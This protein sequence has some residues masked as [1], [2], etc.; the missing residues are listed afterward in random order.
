V[1]YPI[2]QKEWILRARVSPGNRR[3]GWLGNP[4]D[5]KIVGA[6]DEVEEPASRVSAVT[7]RKALYPAVLQVFQAHM[8]VASVTVM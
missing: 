4:I 7:T 3:P 8:S 2:R 5:G 6:K 1:N